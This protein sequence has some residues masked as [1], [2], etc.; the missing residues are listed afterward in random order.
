MYIGICTYV[1]PKCFKQCY[2]HLCAYPETQTPCDGVEY[3]LNLI[4]VSGDLKG[5]VE[6]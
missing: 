4:R 2:V 1:L 3:L 5:A 6:A